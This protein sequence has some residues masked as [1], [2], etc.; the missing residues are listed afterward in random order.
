MGMFDTTSINCPTCGNANTIQSKGGDCVLAEYSSMDETPHD[1]L[2]GLLT[3]DDLILCSSC[4]D[5]YRL[6][7]E[8]SVVSA[9]IVS[10]FVM[11]VEAK[12]SWL[13]LDKQAI[14]DVYHF[15]DN[16]LLF[17][18]PDFAKNKN[19]DIVLTW[20]SEHSHVQLEATFSGD[21][22]YH[23]TL[24]TYNQTVASGSKLI[25][26]A[27]PDDIL[28]RLPFATQL[29]IHDQYIE[30]KLGESLARNLIVVLNLHNDKILLSNLLLA[31]G[32]L[33]EVWDSNYIKTHLYM[34]YADAVYDVAATIAEVS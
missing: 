26:Q 18:V 10:E 33:Y 9:C 13:K 11:W 27:L 34:V 25:D 3:V 2:G 20:K 5:K 29:S 16:H 1:V 32:N 4:G 19:G 7:A 21:G 23:A 24:S 6:Q 17:P 12:D 22:V 15:I 31:T 28:V 14:N 30:N 8:F